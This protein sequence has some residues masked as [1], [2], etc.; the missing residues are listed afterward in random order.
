MAGDTPGIAVDSQ[1]RDIVTTSL[2]QFELDYELRDGRVFVVS[3]PGTARLE[4]AC[5]IEIFHDSI[6]VEAFICRNPDEDFE[7]VYRYLLKRNRRMY[8]VSYTIDNNG[9]IYLAGRVLKHAVTP[10]EIDRILGQVLESADHDFN[11]LIE[12]G[13]HTSIIKEWKWRES[14]GESLANLEPF[15]HLMQPEDDTFGAPIGQ[16]SENPG[17][18]SAGSSAAVHLRGSH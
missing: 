13:F 1:L 8:G 9:D 11:I 6:R 10:D 15:R 5:M 3:L 14:R 2:E 17:A 12:M 4:T 7:R 18:P 16:P